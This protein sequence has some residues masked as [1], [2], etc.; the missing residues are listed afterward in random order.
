MQKM[1]NNLILSFLIYSSQ[2]K[3]L[4]ITSNIRVFIHMQILEKVKVTYGLPIVT[5]VHEPCQVSK[6]SYSN[7]RVI[8]E[9]SLA[10]N[11]LSTE[12]CNV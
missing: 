9:R 2:E 5:D 6:V 7:R 8:F 4:F 3:Q 12:S 11:E 1:E 10:Y